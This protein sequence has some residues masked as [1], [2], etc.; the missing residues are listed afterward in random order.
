V[1][2][3]YGYSMDGA[4]RT[5]DGDAAAVVGR[6]F[7]EFT[8]LYTHAS[9]SEIATSLNVDG[10]PTARGGRWHAST[11]RYVLLNR[12]YTG[13]DGWPVLVGAA[14]FETAQRRIEALRPGPAR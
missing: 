12:A 1:A 2:I 7:D 4:N 6:I 11:V 9:L 5:I 14:T 8:R 10:I 3:P 13:A